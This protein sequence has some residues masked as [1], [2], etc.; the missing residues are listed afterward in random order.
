MAAE[1]T[2]RQIAQQTHEHL[3]PLAQLALEM[4]QIT[5]NY[6]VVDTFKL[7]DRECSQ[8]VTEPRDVYAGN[9]GTMVAMRVRIPEGVI[10]LVPEP[11]SLAPGAKLELPPPAE[12]SYVPFILEYAPLDSEIPFAEDDD[13]E[14][15]HVPENAWQKIAVLVINSI[16]PDDLCL[17]DGATGKDFESDNVPYLRNAIETLRQELMGEAFSALIDASGEDS[18]TTSGS[19]MVRETERYI[20]FDPSKAYVSIPPAKTGDEAQLWPLS[21]VGHRLS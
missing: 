8:V 20:P 17:L 19:V 2:I 11:V 10:A 3:E 18:N 4:Q 1:F 9:D 12:P 16:D 21:E 14:G 6:A 5:A 15:T 7:E 13:R